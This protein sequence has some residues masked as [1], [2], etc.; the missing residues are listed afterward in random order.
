MVLV[1]TEDQMVWIYTVA[2]VE[3]NEALFAPFSL[4]TA[5]LKVLQQRMVEAHSVFPAE[6]IKAYPTVSAYGHTMASVDA[7]VAT[8]LYYVNDAA[9]AKSVYAL[10]EAG[11][12][13]SILL[14]E[15]FWEVYGQ[16]GFDTDKLEELEEKFS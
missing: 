16:A 2:H 5:K 4:L 3:V 9:Q 14:D 10:A 6:L 1:T 12:R 11:R 15:E 7:L 8:L 13:L